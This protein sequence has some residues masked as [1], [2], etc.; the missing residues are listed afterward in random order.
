MKVEVRFRG[1]ERSDALSEHVIRRVHLQL[2]RFSGEVSSVVVKVSDINGP[3]GGVD[4]RCQVTVRG[5][6]LGSVN[7]EDLSGNAYSAVDMAIERAARA[8][9]REVERGRA[10]RR[11]DTV[12]RRA[13]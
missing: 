3:K 5:P 1:V 13:S 8:A 6:S 11:G 4:K 9:G 2:S 12:F 10:S 7:V